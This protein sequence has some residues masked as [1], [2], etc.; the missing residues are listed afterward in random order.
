[1]IYRRTV[2]IEL[3]MFD[4]IDNN[5]QRIVVGN[6]CTKNKETSKD[7]IRS[8]KALLQVKSFGNLQF[9]FTT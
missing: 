7:N 2:V 3:M 8:T 6:I 9:Y 5:K 1:M 4:V